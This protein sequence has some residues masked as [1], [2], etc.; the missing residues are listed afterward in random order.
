MRPIES[1]ALLVLLSPVAKTA[2]GIPIELDPSSDYCKARKWPSW[3]SH[4]EKERAH[5]ELFG[6]DGRYGGPPHHP[7]VTPKG[8]VPVEARRVSRSREQIHFQVPARRSVKR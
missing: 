3:M 8:A 2:N 7:D 6:E 1:R 4:E 5:A